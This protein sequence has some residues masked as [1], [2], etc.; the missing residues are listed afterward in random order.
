MGEGY[1]QR[2]TCPPLP[3]DHRCRRVLNGPAPS[4]DGCQ[5]GG[6]GRQGEPTRVAIDDDGRRSISHEASSVDGDPAHPADRAHDDGDG[7]RNRGLVGQLDDHRRT[8]RPAGQRR[9]GSGHDVAARHPETG[10]EYR[11]GTRPYLSHCRL[12]CRVV[13]AVVGTDPPVDPE[14]STGRDDAAPRVDDSPETVVGTDHRA[15][16]AL[17]YAH[18]RPAVGPGHGQDT[19]GRDRRV[20][21]PAH[22]STGSCPPPNTACTPWAMGTSTPAPVANSHTTPA[23]RTPSAT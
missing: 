19:S 20:M 10:L 12:D 22:T 1:D 6:V 11:S 17:G 7:D 15:V 18:L 23:A 16:D 3:V 14:S 4:H 2:P 8:I 5:V 9:P 13:P 21:R